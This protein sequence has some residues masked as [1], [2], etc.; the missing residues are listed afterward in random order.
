LNRVI[1]ELSGPERGGIFMDGALLRQ[2]MANILGV[3]ARIYVDDLEQ[4]LLL[5]EGADDEIRSRA[6]TLTG[7]DV[8][9][10]AAEVERSG[11]TL[12][13][14]PAPGPNGPRLIARHPDGP[15]LEYIQLE[16]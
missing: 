16:G 9:L 10:I 4:A 1:K 7:R 12:L 11:G 15:V 5:I 13:E 14:G 2:A 6:A 3:L 8:G